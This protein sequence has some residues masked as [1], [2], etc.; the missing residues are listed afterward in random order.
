MEDCGAK[1]HL[2]NHAYIGT[3]TNQDEQKETKKW[4][5]EHSDLI[6]II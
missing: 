3:D 5:V 1:L 4:K 2:Q 6:K